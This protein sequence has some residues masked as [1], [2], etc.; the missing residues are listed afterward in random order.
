MRFRTTIGMIALAT[1]WLVSAGGGAASAQAA[2]TCTWGGTPAAPTGWT[3]NSP[4]LTNFPSPVPVKFYAI[5]AL[6]GDA[7][8]SGK[9]SFTGQVD[10]GSS[11]GFVSFHGTA[12]GLPGVARF[13]GVSALGLAPARLYDRAGDIVGSENAQ[14]LN[15]APFTAC[16]TPQGFTEGTFT[17]VIELIDR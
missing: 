8:C 16:N 4:G 15:N 12:K 9:F 3:T 13:A 1:V 5:G 11:C 10:A 6:A 17:S 7:G 2:T 14:F